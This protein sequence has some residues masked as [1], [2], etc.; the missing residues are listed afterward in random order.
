MRR[1]PAPL[2]LAMLMILAGCAQPGEPSGPGASPDQRDEAFQQRATEVA[3]VWQAAS[4][5]D[6]RTGYVPLQDPTIVPAGATFGEET[7][8]AFLAGW[9]R[10]RV[11]MPPAVPADGT[12]TFPDGT[13]SV[14]LVSAA[15]A[16][17]QL[18]QGDPPPC[19]GRPAQ[20]PPVPS[21]TGPDG[22]VSGP[23]ST[24]CT[25]LTVSKVELGTATVRTSR[26]EATVPAWLF[27]VDELRTTIARVAVA[28]GAT[29]TLPEAPGPSGS[30][31][32]GLVGAQDLVAVDGAKLTYR[33][34]VGACDTQVTPLVREQ[35]DLVL[36]GGTAVRSDG[37][38]TDQ[39][40]L[41]P[42]TVNLE[43]PLGARTVLDA[44]FGRPLILT[45]AR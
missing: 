17:R 22:T 39:L 28:P 16:Y 40:L 33:L 5:P 1:F 18:D 34:G 27:T 11:A 36:V 37:I 30:L 21:G 38:C 44:A 13:L 20:P 26:G 6:W 42:V 24:A 43:Q 4:R 9:Y 31:P 10:E 3:Q 35:D 29:G 23:A 14:P 7:K 12:I 2:G 19:P 45:S 41:Q 25:P 15:E 32:K 8:Q